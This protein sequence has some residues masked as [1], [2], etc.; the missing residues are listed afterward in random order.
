MWLR[1]GTGALRKTDAEGAAIRRFT[2]A[3]TY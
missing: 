1:P 3:A 2:T